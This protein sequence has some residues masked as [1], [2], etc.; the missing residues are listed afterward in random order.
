M[1]LWLAGFFIVMAFAGRGK[2][3]WATAVFMATYLLLLPTYLI[4][5]LLYNFL[6]HPERYRRWERKFLCLRC[7]AIVDPE[8]KRGLR[9]LI[10]HPL[11][12]PVSAFANSSARFFPPDGQFRLPAPQ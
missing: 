11:L 3:S 1:L 10:S 4:V 12:G 9:Q 7:G 8:S 5:T 2:L 6:V